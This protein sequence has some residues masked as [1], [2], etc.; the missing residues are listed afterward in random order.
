MPPPIGRKW[1]I[2]GQ[3]PCAETIRWQGYGIK[4]PPLDLQYRVSQR[5]G[6]TDR[7]AKIEEYL[8]WH[9]N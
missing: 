2:L 5:R 3:R 1:R 7:A 4:V 8:T 9:T 6:L